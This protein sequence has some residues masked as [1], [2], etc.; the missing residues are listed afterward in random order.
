M[1]YNAILSAVMDHVVPHNVRT[2]VVFA[3]AKLQG[4]SNCFKLVGITRFSS[5]LGKQ[6]IPGF[7]IFSQAYGT[8]LC[9]VDVVVFNDPP[10]APVGAN[11]ARLV[12]C[13]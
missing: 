13:W 8:A 9:I 6:V 11:Q 5:G 4:F 10:L 3:P 12:S 2:D 7:L 1:T